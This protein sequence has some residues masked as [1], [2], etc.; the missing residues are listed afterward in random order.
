M[1]VLFLFNTILSYSQSKYETPPENLLPE[2]LKNIKKEI[3]VSNFPKEVDPVKI[4]KTYY[5]KHNT[6]LFSKNQKIKIKEFGAY[7]FY[8]GKWNLRKIY[9]IRDLDKFFG[10]KKQILHPSEPFT[11]NTN[12]RTGN[13]LY[14][15][16]ALWYFI[17]ENED[18]ETICGYEKINTTG[19][20]TKIKS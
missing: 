1:I 18:G 6:T 17:G 9:A 16:W 2:K 5:W 11:W 12:W 7:I 14:G 4:K 10:T 3:V 8:N 20:H 19:N 13:Q 15:G